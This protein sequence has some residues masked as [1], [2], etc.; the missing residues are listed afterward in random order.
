MPLKLEDPF[1]DPDAILDYAFNWRPSE[2]DVE[3][4]PYL[5]EDEDIAVDPVTGDKKIIITV[6]EGLDLIRF[7]E[8][9]GLVT[10]WLSGGEVDHDYLVSCF[11]E[12]TQGRADERSI[13]IR[14]KER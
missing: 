12:T 3:K 7:Y 1:K 13:I 4:G 11:I 6:E 8:N 9:N 14:V 10:V 5:A 2:S